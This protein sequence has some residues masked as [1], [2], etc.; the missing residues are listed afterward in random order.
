MGLEVTADPKNEAG[1]TLGPVPGALAIGAEADSNNR[2][3]IGDIRQVLPPHILSKIEL[4]PS[5]I[6]RVDP[7]GWRELFRQVRGPAEAVLDGRNPALYAE[8]ADSII[9]QITTRARLASM[10]GSS[11][12]VL[13]CIPPRDI[14]SDGT[15]GAI[16]P[17][18]L[19]GV[20]K[21]VWDHCVRASE[22]YGP[23]CQ[24]TLDFWAGLTTDADWSGWNIVIHFNPSSKVEKATPEQAG[25]WAI[26]MIPVKAV[27]EALCARTYAS[28]FSFREGDDVNIEK[29]ITK[30]PGQE[31]YRP[32]HMQDYM[33]KGPAK[34][35]WD[36]CVEKDL[37]PTIEYWDAP[38]PADPQGERISGYE[39]VIHWF[40]PE[41]YNENERQVFSAI[42]EE[43]RSAQG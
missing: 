37:H 24:P 6:E 30:Y 25:E 19:T 31:P 4:D 2:Y 15:V 36:F 10:L 42:D 17:E 28:V 26:K 3:G 22:K 13:A 21:I 23:E 5:I 33:L 43:R 35:L 11:H 32:G 41:V 34:E 12:A 39:I 38:N 8:I 27:L 7:E 29:D 9:Q 20:S 14:E 18:W 16:E 40:Y 1:A